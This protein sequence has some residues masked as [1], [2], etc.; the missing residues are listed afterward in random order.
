MLVKIPTV[1]TV[2]ASA[3]LLDKEADGG[4]DRFEDEVDSLLALD[5]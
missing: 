4:P 5:G 3:A 1:R 2:D